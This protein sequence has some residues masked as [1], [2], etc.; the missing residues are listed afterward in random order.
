MG[1]HRFSLE[2]VLG[3][4]QQCRLVASVWVQGTIVFPTHKLLALSGSL[5]GPSPH[6]PADPHAQKVTLAGKLSTGRSKRVSPT[7][8]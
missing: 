7:V 2:G 3:K 5:P 1:L 8:L 4:L 6:I